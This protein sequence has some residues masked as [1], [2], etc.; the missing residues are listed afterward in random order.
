MGEAR[1]PAGGMTTAAR[2]QISPAP[3]GFGLGAAM[4][5][6]IGNVVG[7]G[8]FLLPA[9]LAVFGVLSLVAMA[10]VTVGALAMALVF[11]RL[12]ARIPV[13]GGPYVYARD[14]FGEF[15]GFWTAWSFWLTAW[16]GNAAVAV[17]WTGYARYLIQQMFRQDVSGVPAAIAIGLAGLWIPAV[18]NLMGIRDMAVFQ[19]VTTI[20]KFVPLLFVAVV[21]LFFLSADNFGPF[22]ATGVGWVRA[23]SMAGAVALF[24]YTGVESAAIA[25]SRMRDPARDVGRASVIGVSACAVLYV[26]STVVVMGTVPHQ[27]LVHSTAPFA[28]ALNQMFGGLAG[29]LVMAACATISGIGTLNGWT[30]LAAE[31]PMAAARDGMFPP[32]F[33]RLTRRGAPYTGILIGTTL[34]SLMLLTGYTSQNAFDTIVLL[35]S[36]TTVIP[37]F[38]SAAAQLSWLMTGA[39]R[40]EGRRLARDTTI[41]VIAL[42]F[43]FWMAYGS[44]AQ[45]VLGGTLMLLVGVPVYIWMKAT[46]GEYGPRDVHVWEGIHKQ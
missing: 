14:A 18:V 10:L 41:S 38:F 36:F 22:N 43:A 42:L 37:Y 27:Q 20:L 31:M 26:L 9:A 1:P 46:R 44:G 35:A 33:A 12:G 13:G 29:G 21:G 30:L 17:A 45:A 39:R 24:I 32:A 8:I 25:A 15:T 4:A 5:L 16:I 6:V 7:T 34:A 19:V 40:V 3:G 2:A 23:V 11:G 28:D